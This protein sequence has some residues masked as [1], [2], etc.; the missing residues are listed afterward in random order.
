MKLSSMYDNFLSANILNLKLQDDI[1]NSQKSLLKK[2]QLIQSYLIENKGDF[3]LKEITIDNFN[4]V[5]VCIKINMKESIHRL[6]LEKMEGT[7]SN[8]NFFQRNSHPQQLI[9]F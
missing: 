1:L 3:F 9:T 5:V 6:I 7:Y 8:G 2:Y 4:D